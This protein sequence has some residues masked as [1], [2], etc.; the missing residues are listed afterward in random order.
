MFESTGVERY[1][2]IKVLGIGGGGTNAVNRMIESGVSGVDFIA[3]NTDAQVLGIS[4]AERKLQIGENI[5]KGL[6]AG[7]N[8]ELGRT[9][10]EE[11]RQEIKAALEGADMVFV[12]AGLG[13]GTGTGAAPIVAEVSKELGA[14]TVAFVTKPFSFEGPRRADIAQEGVTVLRSTVDAVVTIPNDRLLPVLENQNATLVEAFRAA[15]DILRQGVQGISDIICVPGMINVDFADVKSVMQDAGTALMGIG[16]ATG[17]KRAAESAEKATTSALLETPIDGA[18]GL[19]MNV[20]GGP[21]MTLAEVYECAEAIT[22]HADTHTANIIFG[23]V[24]D[25]QLEGEM[26]VILLATGFEAPMPRL[27]A[28][29]E[30]P[31][32][33]DEALRVP[34]FTEESDLDVPAFL[35]RR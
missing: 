35:R 1:A 24:V 13:G 34:A 20:T 15:D 5:T 9:A 8:P 2:R 28:K 25:P 23:T 12:T 6:G 33:V 26:R 18:T 27:P 17:D 11:S 10:A 31:D 19:L 16:T 29:A 21:D 4:A 7:G 32:A 22:K 3:L 30:A 14:L